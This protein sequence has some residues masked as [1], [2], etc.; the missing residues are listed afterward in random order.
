LPLLW[1]Q[2]GAKSPNPLLLL[3]PL[4]RLPL[5]PLLLLILPPPPPPLPL[6]LLSTP[7]PLLPPPLLPLPIASAKSPN[8]LPP[9]LPLSQLPLEPA[10]LLIPPPLPLLSPRPLLALLLLAGIG[11]GAH[12]G[13]HR[14]IKWIAEEGNFFMNLYDLLNT[15]C[16]LLM[17]MHFFQPYEFVL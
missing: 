11:L 6:P 14:R 5:E 3:L 8:L 16:R 15:N 9:L 17:C 13:L 1:P 2:R 7:L 4:R 12:Q 10:L